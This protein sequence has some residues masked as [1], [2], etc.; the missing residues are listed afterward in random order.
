MLN[1]EEQKKQWAKLQQKCELNVD[2]LLS[3]DDFNNYNK[4]LCFFKQTKVASSSILEALIDCG[5]N[6]IK[7]LKKKR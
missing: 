1:N 7:Y 4:N 2:S 6:D 5:L 3:L